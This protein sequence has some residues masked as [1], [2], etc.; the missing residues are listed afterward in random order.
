MVTR[1]HVIQYIHSS[2]IVQ[3]K[4]FPSKH[5]Q[6]QTSSIILHSKFYFV[7]QL[8]Q[9]TVFIKLVMSSSSRQMQY[10][11]QIMIRKDQM[12]NSCRSAIYM[13]Y[14]RDVSKH[15]HDERRQASNANASPLISSGICAI[16]EQLRRKHSV[17]C[18]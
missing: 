6:G 1:K 17:Q 12:T 10:N 15:F 4:R 13:L 8:Q 5:L 11:K 3:C 9:S 16:N 18:S 7:N 2:K 14:A